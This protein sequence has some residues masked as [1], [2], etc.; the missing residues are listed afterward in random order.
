MDVNDIL[1]FPESSTTTPANDNEYHNQSLL[2]LTDLEDCCDDPRQRRGTWYYPDGT[3][4]T[5]NTGSNNFRR[6]RGPNQ[7]LNDQQFYGSV[8]LYRRGNP[9]E[10]GRFHCELP[11]AANPFVNQTIYVNI[12]ELIT[13]TKILLL[14]TIYLFPYN[15]WTLEKWESHPLAPALQGQTSHWRAQQIS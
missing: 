13:T 3:E 11:N 8:R 15:Q 7:V 1:Q 14:Y 10:R 4:V 12:C 5:L 9:T 2:C 6:N